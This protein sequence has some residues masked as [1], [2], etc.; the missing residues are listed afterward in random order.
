MALRPAAIA[1][2]AASTTRPAP[3]SLTISDMPTSGVAST[4]TPRRI[5]SKAARPKFSDS[6]VIA[7]TR[8]AANSASLSAPSTWRATIVTRRSTPSARACAASDAAWPSASSPAITTRAA[9]ASGSAAISRS[10]AF[11]Q[12]MPAEGQHQRS[13]R[14]RGGDVGRQRRGGRRRRIVDAVRDGGDG[15]QLPAEAGKVAGLDRRG[16]MDGGGRLESWR[17]RPA[18]STR[19]SP[20]GSC[21]GS[22]RAR[23]CRAA[24]R[25]RARPARARRV[26]P[27]RS[28]RDRRRADARRRSRRPMRQARGASAAT[29]RGGAAGG[30][31]SR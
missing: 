17:A 3:L 1:A 7:N 27:P 20:S 31:E 5:A 14:Y 25:H 19:P 16:R 9:G 6:D 13:R 18:R 8:A 26:R 22:A 24:R 11:S 21:G 30:S 2:G 28:A 4:G 23:A 10:S 15:R 29:N 12:L